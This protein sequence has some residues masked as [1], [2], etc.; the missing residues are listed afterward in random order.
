[1][2]GIGRMARQVFQKFRTAFS[3]YSRGAWNFHAPRQYID[4]AHQIS[5]RRTNNSQRVLNQ[6]IPRPEH[7]QHVPNIGAAL[8]YNLARRSNWRRVLNIHDICWCTLA[9][10]YTCRTTLIFD[11]YS[12]GWVGVPGV[13]PLRCTCTLSPGHTK[14]LWEQIRDH[15]TLHRCWWDVVLN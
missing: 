15:V 8:Q 10:T 9:G 5:T 11:L 7:S 1:M 2:E 14:K 13:T 4:A 6:Y 12:S 3:I